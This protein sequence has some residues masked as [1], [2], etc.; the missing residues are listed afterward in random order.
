MDDDNVK[1]SIRQVKKGLTYSPISLI[2]NKLSFCLCKQKIYVCYVV[3]YF[4][5]RLL[6]LKHI[7]CRIITE[8]FTRGI[9]IK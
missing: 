1:L 3:K 2:L 5:S 8:T 9:L 6:K 4:M 7:R